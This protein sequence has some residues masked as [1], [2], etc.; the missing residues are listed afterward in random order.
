MVRKL[1]IAFL[2]LIQ[3][4]CSAL[5]IPEPTAT[6]TPPPTATSTPTVVPTATATEPPTLVV[7][8]VQGNG[9]SLD[10]SNDL[11]VDVQK[12]VVGI[13]DKEGMLIITF[14]RTP[15]DASTNTLQD[16]ID[17]YL[18]ELAERGGEFIQSDASPVIVGGAEGLSIDLTGTLFD[19]PIEGKAIAVTPE[20]NSVFFGLGVSN[21]SNDGELWQTTG[22]V[23]FQGLIDSLQFTSVQSNG[24]CTVSTDKTYGYTEANPIKVGGDFLEGPA[25]ERA[26]LDNLLGPNGESLSY[27]R[28]GSLP[29]G[30]T[31]LDVYRVTGGGL[32]VKLY[33]DEYQFLPLQAPV[34]FTCIDEFISAP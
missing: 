20:N 14:T 26:Y 31:I 18:N 29:S 23:I 10:V 27:E 1:S 28:Q 6:S 24:T 19:A 33:L 30:D 17:E 5:A 7:S 9:F 16:V 25:R 13:Y 11:D 15:Y 3:T 12:N 32:D 34:G 22:S 2:V 21:L 8:T 4:A